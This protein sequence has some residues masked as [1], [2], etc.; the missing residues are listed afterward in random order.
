MSP[1][2]LPTLIRHL[3]R[4]PGANPSADAELVRRFVVLRDGEAFE[5]L[6]RRHGPLV[7]G[8][9]RRRL[10]NRADAEDAFQSTFLVLAKRAAAIRRPEALGC[11]LYGV[12]HRVAGR[13]R[14]RSLP[15]VPDPSPPSAAVPVAEAATVREFL[16][17]LDEELL[18]L[19]EKLRGPLVLCFLQERTQDEA[20]KQLGVSL[21]TLKRR[22]D[23]GRELLR[24][25]LSG[26]GVELSAALAAVGLAV[27]SAVADA[28]VQAAVNGVSA[29]LVSANVLTVTEGVVRAMTYA[30]LKA[31]TAGVLMMAASAGGTGYFAYTGYSQTS[32]P[33]GGGPAGADPARTADLDS[34][35]LKV[36][37]FDATIAVRD[38]EAKWKKLK[39]DRDH[40]K[41]ISQDPKA[42]AI[43]RLDDA[44]VL[45]QL[46]L[47]V[48]R[49]RLK[50]IQD[51]LAATKQPPGD[52]PDLRKLRQEKLKA[53]RATLT[54][55][56]AAQKQGRPSDARSAQ[57]SAANVYDWSKRVMEA[58]R[59]LDPSAA[60]QAKAAR[61]HFD[62]MVQLER[63]QVEPVRAGVADE[64]ARAAATFYRLEAEVWLR[65]ADAPRRRSP[66]G[67]AAPSEVEKLRLEL[68]KAKVE[69]AA[70]Q[71][72]AERLEEMLQKLLDEFKPVPPVLPRVREESPAVPEGFRGT[73]RRTEGTARDLHAGNEVWVEITPGMDAGLRQGAILTVRRVDGAS[74]KYLGTITVVR[75]NAKDAVSRFTPA[76]P[77]AV[78]DAD[79]PKP[80]DELVPNTQ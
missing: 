69:A 43:I 58:E 38:L 76:N 35:R 21:S 59:E 34:L 72:R 73:V 11:W 31:W 40:L 7:W 17:L 44:L 13:M 47:E 66:E 79:L 70:Q 14:G 12:A 48:A 26:R 46:D 30:K 41:Q 75:A 52:T 15:T 1:G 9:C 45:T 37:I 20:A 3:R 4:P 57:A 78:T 29:G 56:L 65:K 16:V 53:A 64:Q 71:Q 55:V 6:L 54:Y 10:S 80:G 63:L 19:P 49:Q 36:E 28:A 51:K 33:D 67:G 8:V 62:R 25:R 24:V 50:T 27:P 74:A 18:R 68:E 39:A 42:Q 2:L 77:R 61:E 5:E 32:S 60:N 22:L 23:A